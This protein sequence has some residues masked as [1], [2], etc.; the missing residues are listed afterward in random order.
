MSQAMPEPAEI[1]KN[2]QQ[3]SA[4]NGEE[5]SSEATRSRRN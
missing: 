1:L 2:I 4:I 3:R 5:K